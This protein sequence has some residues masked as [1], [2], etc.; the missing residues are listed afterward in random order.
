VGTN[1]SVDW[2]AWAFA[3]QLLS[4]TNRTSTIWVALTNIASLV[5]YQNVVANGT[6]DSQLF[7]RLKK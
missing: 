5:A 7:F 4:S 3:Y 1:N 6:A 2:P